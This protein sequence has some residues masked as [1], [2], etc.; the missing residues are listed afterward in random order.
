MSRATMSG[1]RI[2]YGQRSIIAVDVLTWYQMIQEATA[3]EPLTLDEEYIMQQSWRKDNDKLT[4]IVS[5]PIEIRHQ[6]KSPVTGTH[7]VMLGDVN[8]FISLSEDSTTGQPIVIGELELMIAEND[9]QNRGFGKAALLTFLQYVI[10][11]QQ[12]ILDEFSNEANEPSKA[13]TFNYFTAKIGKDNARS[14][15]LFGCLGF[16]KTREEPNYWGEFELRHSGLTRADVQK[17]MAD[18]GIYQYNELDYDT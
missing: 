5:R 14:L 18:Y 10:N 4:F 17:M 12:T 2:R 6:P 9:Q 7:E 16:E 15:A 1:C 13:T 11:H 3:S 8:M